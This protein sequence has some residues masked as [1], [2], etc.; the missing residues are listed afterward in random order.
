MLI[1][2]NV[3]HVMNDLLC[4]ILQQKQMVTLGIIS[5]DR[6]E[7]DTAEM[8]GSI[9]RWLSSGEL[10]NAVTTSMSELLE[11]TDQVKGKEKGTDTLKHICDK[12]HNEDHKFS[13]CL[14]SGITFKLA[15]RCHFSYMY[16]IYQSWIHKVS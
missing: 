6:E 16:C 8:H 12:F 7:R 5:G 4:L 9:L 15:C 1:H 3:S 11:V 13:N 2:T 10:L 14:V